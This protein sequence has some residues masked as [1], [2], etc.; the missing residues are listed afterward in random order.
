MNKYLLFFFF[1]IFLTVIPAD[2]QEYVSPLHKNP[3]LSQNDDSQSIFKSGTVSDT[4]LP[5]P[6]LDDFS[7]SGP[8]PS[9]TK[10]IDRNAFIN[11]TFALDPITVGV[12]TLDCLDPNGDFHPQAGTRSFRSD[13]L[14]SRPINLGK[15]VRYQVPGDLLLFCD[16]QTPVNDSLYYKDQEDDFLPLSTS[17]YLY[18]TT[19]NL[20]KKGTYERYT[21]SLC[22][23]DKAGDSI[24][25]FPPYHYYE[26]SPADSII[27]SFFCQPQ[28]LNDG[29]DAEDSLLVEFF[30]PVDSS[31]RQVFAIPGL[32]DIKWHYISIPLTENDYLNAGF[33][34]RLVNKARLSGE[35]SIPGMIGN[36]DHWHIDYVYLDANR[37]S[38]T[39][40]L[41]DA[42]FAS[43]PG[44]IIKSLR[45][46][47]WSH[48]RNTTAYNTLRQNEFPF[49]LNN[50]SDF[51][52]WYYNIRIETRLYPEG[53][54]VHQ[55][56]LGDYE[57]NHKDTLIHFNRAYNYLLDQPA[58]S[59]S[60]AFQ[61]RAYFTPSFDN[62]ESRDI[63][64]SN[65]TISF[66]QR[67]YNYY[68]Y[69]DGS[70]ENGYGVFDA[71]PIETR[72]TNRFQIYR[73]DTLRGLDIL[74]N[75]S[76]YAEE[77]DKNPIE[78]GVWTDNKGPSERFLTVSH[79]S[80]GQP[81]YPGERGTNRFK[82][83]VFPEPTYLPA[84]TYFFGLVQS[85]GTYINI[86]LDKNTDQSEHIYYYHKGDWH[87]SK[88]KGS[89]MI[90][91]VLGQDQLLG[92]Q[93]IQEENFKFLLFPNPAQD[94]LRIQSS[95]KKP[96][97]YQI[98][99]VQGQVMASGMAADHTINIEQLAE[100][101]YLLSLQYD[102][103]SYTTKFIKSY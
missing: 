50:L 22:V 75:A 53:T 67:F 28:G 42:A 13:S 64:P 78:L 71:D 48:F 72:I 73:S 49:S 1:S 9:Q 99:S 27:L 57:L 43:N 79:N 44:S 19:Q 30:N 87:A 63:N 23:Y 74:Y 4:Q 66:I 102:N 7:Y 89:L 70:P 39:K 86:G 3:Q 77:I 100:G 68:A 93:T 103:R 40:T 56:I 96:I 38:T 84:G 16:S 52:M 62:T 46:L 90:R 51:T 92:T 82:R 26:V 55:D 80:Q 33:Q 31:W 60:L 97:S 21:N 17:G 54:S 35:Q 98:R 32:Q 29:L 20:Y 6:F 25:P 61:I 83:Y 65:D 95:Y 76:Y 47:P 37:T 10:W 2:G 59:D 94:F 24:H 15:L 8:Y 41:N 18:D 58:S 12:A 69:D 91:P 36:F 101:L 45:A 5:L 34:F 11:Q 85:D 14:T 88:V 81:L